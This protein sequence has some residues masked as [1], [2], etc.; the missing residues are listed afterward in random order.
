M[1]RKP[2]SMKRLLSLT[3][4]EYLDRIYAAWMGKSLGGTIGAPMENYKTRMAYTRED[5]WPSRIMPNDDMDIQMVWLEALQER[6]VWL[7]SADLADYWQDRCWYNFCEYGVFLHNRQRGIQPPLSGTWNNRF[8]WESEGCPIRSEIWS[9]VCPGNPQLAADYARADGQLD[10]GGASV[11]CEMFLAAAGAAA[12]FD[13]DL[14]RVLEAGLAVLPA[15]DPV[16]DMVQYTRAICVAHP[17]FEDAWRLLIRRYGDRDASKALVNQAI[18]VMALTLARGDFAETMRLCVNSGWDTDCTAATAGALLGIMHGSAILPADWV[19]KMGTHLACNIEVRHK[20]ASFEAL[21]ADTAG[22]GLEV[23]ALRSPR[24]AIT[25]APAVP[26]RPAP[27]PGVSLS[28]TYP[29]GPWLRAAGHT[30]VRLRLENRTDETRRG[31]WTL[32][33]ADHLVA[34][35]GGGALTLAPGEV[36][37]LDVHLRPQDGPVWDRN[38]LVLRWQDGQGEVVHAFGLGG[39]RVWR[40]YGPY[41]DMYDT[42]AHANNPHVNA[43]GSP[44]PPTTDSWNQY[45]RLDKA[46]LDEGRLAREEIPEELPATIEVGEDYL[47]AADIAGFTGQAVFYLVREL[48]CADE[49]EIAFHITTIAPHAVWFDG[50]ELARRAHPQEISLQ[51]GHTGPMPVGPTPKRLVVKVA[52]QADAFAMCAMPQGGG[53]PTHQRGISMFCDRLGDMPPRERQ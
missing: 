35:V 14:D 3:Y 50:K 30:P 1:K 6:G 27:P 39:A 21:T 44:R 45:A 32:D 41:F 17:R 37:E 34:S 25:D 49:R 26:L 7:T 53:D 20:T 48:V 46:Y 28:V 15:G 22:V 51:D 5:L 40:V 2:N 52:R 24:V 47:D 29:R 36:L 23:T 42:I 38:P 33:V 9:L 43:D 19:E 10:H 18:V 8:F 4:S 13:D 12:F 31:A 11:S 16:R